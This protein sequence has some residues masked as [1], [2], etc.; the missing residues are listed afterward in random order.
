MFLK[1]KF[2]YFRQNEQYDLRYSD[3]YGEVEYIDRWNVQPADREAWL[4][5]RVV[6]PARHI[7]YYFDDKFPEIWKEPIRRGIL[8]WN[9]VFEEMGLKDVIQ[10][11]DYP[12]DDPEFDEDNLSYS[13]IRYIPTDRGGSQGPSWADPRT[14]EMFC[15]NAYYR[16]LARQIA[17]Y[18]E[19]SDILTL[20]FAD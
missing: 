17:D 2:G 3:L 13:C 15:A 12:K 4:K 9:E 10:V 19:K 16:Q 5:D 20:K 18:A 11:K 14:G 8:Q 7:V 6:D 1:E